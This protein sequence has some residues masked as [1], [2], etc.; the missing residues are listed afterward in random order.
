MKKIAII[1]SCFIFFGCSNNSDKKDDFMLIDVHSFCQIEENHVNRNLFTY[2]PEEI[3]IYFD[4][5]EAIVASENQEKPILMIFTAYSCKSQRD[6]DWQIFDNEK[7]IELIKD[8]FIFTLLLVDNNSKIKEN[9]IND[10]GVEI[11]TIGLCY[12]DLQIKKY[13]R[14]AQP[15]YCIVDHNLLDQVQPITYT[16]DSK[17]GFVFLNKGLIQYNDS[18]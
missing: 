14:N 15:L 13:K 4:L 1:I 11:N 7:C 12:H 3:N 8:K 17:V 16:T 5:N 10:E 9:Y 18:W 6:L 2:I